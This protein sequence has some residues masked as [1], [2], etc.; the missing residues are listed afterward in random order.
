M[1]VRLREFH[2]SRIGPFVAFV[3]DARSGALA[4]WQ[5]GLDGHGAEPNS[6]ERTL[7]GTH[8]QYPGRSRR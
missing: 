3:D 2:R 1:F 4:R 8:R 5:S 6:S 7:S